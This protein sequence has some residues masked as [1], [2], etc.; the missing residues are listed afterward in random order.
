MNF[1]KWLVENLPDFTDYEGRERSIRSKMD[2]DGVDWITAGMGKIDSSV[3]QNEIINAWKWIVQNNF[4]G[5][6]F[7][8]TDFSDSNVITYKSIIG[9][10]VVDFS[11]AKH[12]QGMLGNEFSATVDFGWNKAP[13][14][15]SDKDAR[16]VSG[17]PNAVGGGNNAVGQALQKGSL[18]FM[19]AI[20]EKYI[21]PLRH[22]HINVRFNSAD[23]DATDDAG[24][25]MARR[26]RIYD[27]MIRGAGYRKG[28]IGRMP[29]YVP[30]IPNH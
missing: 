18:D 22:Y 10:R 9:D 5:G 6:K 19:R 20:T 28:N 12:S 2:R 17:D 23:A 7:G 16:I 25:D 24:N 26:S 4:P 21:K 13:S 11:L 15:L 14:K 3:R 27:K 1:K 29:G 30:D 8:N